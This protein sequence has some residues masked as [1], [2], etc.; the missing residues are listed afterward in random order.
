[1]V[2]IYKHNRRPGWMV[3]LGMIAYDSLSLRKTPPMHRRL[4]TERTR[5]PFP[6]RRHRRPVRIA[7][8]STTARSRT[9]S[10]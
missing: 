9:P 4:T 6:G 3:E 5:T 2:P 10:G 7:W 8:C 1:M